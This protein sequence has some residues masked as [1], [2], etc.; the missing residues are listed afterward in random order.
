MPPRPQDRR[1][2]GSTERPTVS[3]TAR[4]AAERHRQAETGAAGFAKRPGQDR[5]WQAA[6]PRQQRRTDNPPRRNI[7]PGRSSRAFRPDKRAAALDDP[8]HWQRKAAQAAGSK[9]SRIDQGP[10]GCQTARSNARGRQKYGPAN[11]PPRQQCAS[12]ACNEPRNRPRR[13]HRPQDESAAQRQRCPPLSLRSVLRTAAGGAYAPSRWTSHRSGRF[14]CTARLWRALSDKVFCWGSKKGGGSGARSFTHG[15]AP[16]TVSSKRQRAQSERKTV[17]SAK[18][19]Q[20][21][22]APGHPPGPVKGYRI[23]K[24]GAHGRADVGIRAARRKGQGP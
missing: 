11:G 10:T 7:A 12:G 20:D 6:R 5:R 17:L 8:Q 22:F 24:P 19:G 23:E 21:L 1:A 18:S 3:Q 15:T 14:A 2:A 9:G 13:A 16:E 4:S